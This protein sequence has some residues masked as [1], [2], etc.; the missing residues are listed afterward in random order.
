MITSVKVILPIWA[1]VTL[2]WVCVCLI[3]LW[4]GRRCQKTIAI[5][6]TV[7][8]L[9]VTLADPEYFHEHELNRCRGDSLHGRSAEALKQHSGIC[10]ATQQ[11]TRQ[12]LF[13]STLTQ[14]GCQALDRLYRDLLINPSNV[15]MERV[16]KHQVFRS[17][18]WHSRFFCELK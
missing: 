5:I 6:R 2:K 11:R 7:L 16:Q 13:H 14:K 15:P 10:V 18:V 9:Q 8:N 17:A 4:H 1:A 12:I 3:N